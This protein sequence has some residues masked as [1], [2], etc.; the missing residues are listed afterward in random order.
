MRALRNANRLLERRVAELRRQLQD[1][2]AVATADW[3]EHR[4]QHERLELLLKA[5]M[6]EHQTTEGER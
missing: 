5:H 6:T 3:H 1:V 4:A 2:D